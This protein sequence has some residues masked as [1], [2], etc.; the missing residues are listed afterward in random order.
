MRKQGIKKGLH[1]CSPFFKK[2]KNYLFLLTC[3]YVFLALALPSAETLPAEFKILNLHR[4]YKRDHRSDFFNYQSGR[5]H[6]RICTAE[7]SRLQLQGF[8]SFS[9]GKIAKFC[10]FSKQADLERFLHGKR[11]DRNFFLDGNREF[12]LSGSASSRSEKI[13]N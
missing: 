7:K 6:R 11:W 3:L 4:D 12:H 5:D 9:R 1:F 8:E 13:R 10:R 2:N